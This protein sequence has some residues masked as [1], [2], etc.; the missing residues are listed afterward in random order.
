MLLVLTVREFGG[1]SNSTVKG[2]WRLQFSGRVNLEEV[3]NW[4]WVS[5]HPLTYV[6]PFLSL[7]SPEFLVAFSPYTYHILS[8]FNYYQV[9]LKSKY[10]FRINRVL[11]RNK[12]Q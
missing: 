10:T 2:D 11:Q 1:F 9:I 6:L 5:C 4:S 8:V 12:N 3:S 7:P